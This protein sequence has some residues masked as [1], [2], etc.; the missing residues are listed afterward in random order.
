MANLKI[1][2]LEA[3]ETI[4]L[5]AN[6]PSYL[7]RHYRNNQSV[8]SFANL[9]SIDELVSEIDRVSSLDISSRTLEDIVGAYSAIVALTFKSSDEIE[10]AS[11][12]LSFENILWAEQIL[13]LWEPE[14]TVE[15]VLTVEIGTPSTNVMNTL[16]VITQPC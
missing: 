16:S 10:R 9:H 2:N 12:K 13:Y 4:Y 1:L 6:T 11:N 15:A 7:L 5:V 3:L 8:Q 14:P